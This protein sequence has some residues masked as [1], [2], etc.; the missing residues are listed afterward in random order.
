[1]NAGLLM[2]RNPIRAGIGESGNVRVTIFDHQV[3]VKGNIHS[4][5][6]GR[7]Y[8]RPDGDVGHKVTVHHIHM[9]Q[10]G[11]TSHRSVGILSQAGE[12]G[13]QNGRRYF[14]QNV[15]LSRRYPE[16]I[17]T[18]GTAGAVLSEA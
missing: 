16:E 15:L 8:R 12:I 14:N 9:E 4:L 10:G 17:L 11:A 18:R 2:D 5:A 3:A 7:N 1:V 6:Q 13:R